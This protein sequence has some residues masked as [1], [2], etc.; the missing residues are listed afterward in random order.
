[1]T[2]PKYYKEYIKEYADIT[3][4]KLGQT[5]NNQNRQ[6]ITKIL[7]ILYIVYSIQF[8]IQDKDPYQAFLTYNVPYSQCY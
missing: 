7:Y 6:Q 4:P 1:M 8:Q 3:K 2:F 5:A